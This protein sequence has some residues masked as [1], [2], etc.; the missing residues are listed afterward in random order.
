MLFFL[1]RGDLCLNQIT[2][3]LDHVGSLETWWMLLL[4]ATAGFVLQGAVS[5]FMLVSSG[6]VQHL[7]GLV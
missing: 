2:K 3:G 4:F 7:T 5:D 1:K 6:V